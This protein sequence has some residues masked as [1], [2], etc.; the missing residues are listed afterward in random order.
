[1]KHFK[2]FKT[3]LSLDTEYWNV[4]KFS[5]RATSGVALRQGNILVGLKKYTT[6]QAPI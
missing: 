6:R 4:S 1:M 2:V 5:E 3:K